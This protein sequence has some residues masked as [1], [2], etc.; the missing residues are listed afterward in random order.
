MDVVDKIVSTPQERKNA[1]FQ[2]VPKS[3]VLIK[4]V[5]AVK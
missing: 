1:V 4:S 3:P 5:K 2:N